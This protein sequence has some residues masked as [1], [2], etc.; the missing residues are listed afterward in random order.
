MSGAAVAITQLRPMQLLKSTALSSVAS[1]ASGHSHTMSLDA[2]ARGSPNQST[3][4]RQPMATTSWKAKRDKRVTTTCWPRNPSA[5]KPPSAR[6]PWHKQ[7]ASI[8]L[9]QASH[10]SL[11]ANRLHRHLLPT[12]MLCLA[13]PRPDVQSLLSVWCVPLGAW[14]EAGTEEDG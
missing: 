10:C 3:D 4:S 11:T 2:R 6:A 1:V 9:F 14:H 13:C 8:H 5:G 12:R 7:A